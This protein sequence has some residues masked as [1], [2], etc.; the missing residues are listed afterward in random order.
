[1]TTTPKLG[2]NVPSPYDNVF[3]ENFSENMVV[4]DNSV[5]DNRT[6]NGHALSEN[7]ELS[8]TD[9][10]ARAMTNAEIDAIIDE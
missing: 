4:L 3:V 1:M 5:P 7:I 10:N 8:L 6:I 9:L 2:L